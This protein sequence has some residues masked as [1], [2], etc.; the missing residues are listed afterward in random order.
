MTRQ[1]KGC[2]LQAIEARRSNQHGRYS[3]PIA[4]IQG[5]TSRAEGLRSCNRKSLRAGH[6]PTTPDKA[7][8]GCT[9]TKNVSRVSANGSKPVS[10]DPGS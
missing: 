8:S 5:V 9:S 7:A 10:M 4:A 2:Q 3:P 6:Y 1:V